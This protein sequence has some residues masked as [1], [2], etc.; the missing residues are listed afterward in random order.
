MQ[1]FSEP[2]ISQ[3]A[4]IILLTD[5]GVRVKDYYSFVSC[6]EAKAKTVTSLLIIPSVLGFG[7]YF[8]NGGCNGF[9]TIKKYLIFESGLIPNDLS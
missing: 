8:L 3:G 2:E 9:L 7:F 6:A 4:G 1:L 5:A